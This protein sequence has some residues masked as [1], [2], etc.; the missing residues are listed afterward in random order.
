MPPLGN[1]LRT[2]STGST[3]ST[4]RVDHPVLSDSETTGAGDVKPPINVAP[5]VYVGPRSRPSTAD[6]PSSST[7]PQKLTTLPGDQAILLYNA[8]CKTC[9]FLSNWVKKN[10]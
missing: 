2:G 10:D 5:D 6:A 1:D 4:N 3:G 9:R 7:V 8:D